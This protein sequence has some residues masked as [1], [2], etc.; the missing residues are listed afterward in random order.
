MIPHGWTHRGQLNPIKINNV[1]ADAVISNGV[2]RED[3]VRILNGSNKI[4]I[5]NV[6]WLNSRNAAKAYGSIVVIFTKGSEAERFL[7][8]R[9]FFVGEESALV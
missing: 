7:R 3:L 1:K 2:L 4:E 5:A 6:S 9:R 8:E